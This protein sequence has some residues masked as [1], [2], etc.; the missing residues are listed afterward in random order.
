MWSVTQQAGVFLWINSV[1]KKKKEI[2]TQFTLFYMGLQ[3]EVEFFS[4]NEEWKVL[5]EVAAIISTC[6]I[7]TQLTATEHQTVG[8][9]V[10]AQL[11]FSLQTTPCGLRG[12]LCVEEKSMWAAALQKD[13][14]HLLYLTS[15]PVSCLH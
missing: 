14:L 12:L 9:Q 13:S 6:H 8:S 10:T 7:C 1:K 2:K 11:S 3:S 15:A 5:L 4:S